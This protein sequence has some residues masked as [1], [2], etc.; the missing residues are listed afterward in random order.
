MEDKKYE[1]TDA[2]FHESV[3]RILDMGIAPKELLHQFPCFV[4][5]VNIARQLFLY[6]RYKQVVDLCGHIADVG[7]WKGSSFFLFAKLVMLFERQ[8]QTQVH[9]FDWFKGMQPEQGVDK[10][11]YEGAYIADYEQVS[12]LVGIQRL[13]GVARLHK[14]DLVNELE[15]FF[16]QNPQMR[17]KLVFLD[18]G[19]RAVLESSMKH[20]WHR[21]V[22]GGILVLDHY[23]NSCSPNESEIVDQY[24][25]GRAIRQ[26]PFA[27]QPSAYVVK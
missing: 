25:Q 3:N 12:S 4:G 20:F 5:H 8:C 1:H 17:F 9:G 11:G 16:E 14:L 6:E 13:E 21:L 24:T 19:V 18:C 22:P 15:A 2:A 10:P 23:N 26:E 7:T 27:R